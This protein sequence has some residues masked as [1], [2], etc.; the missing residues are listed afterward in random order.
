MSGVLNLGNIMNHQIGSH[1]C[2]GFIFRKNKFFLLKGSN[3]AAFDRASNAS[4]I[5][6]IMMIP[7]GFSIY[8]FHLLKSGS[9]KIS[10]WHNAGGSENSNI[11]DVPNSLSRLP[12]LSC[13][14][15]LA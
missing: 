4:M 8:I 13:A 14:L 7:N 9:E 5:L 1:H 12:V 3:S 6:L 15:T 10:N 2:N 11:L